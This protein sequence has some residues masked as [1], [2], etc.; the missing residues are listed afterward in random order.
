[1]TTRLGW[2]LVSWPI[3]VL[4][5][6]ASP[7]PLPQGFMFDWTPQG[8]APLAPITAQCD[9]VHIKW[10]RGNAEGPSPIAPYYLQVYTSTFDVPLVVEVGSVLEFDWTVPFVPGTQYQI[11][12]FDSKGVSG[13]CQAI[14]TVYQAPNTTLQSPPTCPNLTYP[15][16]EQQIGVVGLVENGPFS[17]FAT[18]DQCTDLSIMPTNGTPPYTLSIAPALHPH[19]NISSMDQSPINWTVSLSSGMSFFVSLV[20]STGMLW[21]SGPLF[22]GGGGNTNCLSLNAATVDEMNLSTTGV[23]LPVAV[24]I[25][26]TILGLAVGLFSAWIYRSKLRRSH[27]VTP[28][29]FKSMEDEKTEDSL[30]QSLY[31]D[32]EYNVLSQSGG[33][34]AFRLPVTPDSAMSSDSVT[35][36]TSADSTTPLVPLRRHSAGASPHLLLESIIR[37]IESDEAVGGDAVHE[38]EAAI[39]ERPPSITPNLSSDPSHPNPTPLSTCLDGPSRLRSGRPLPVPSSPPSRPLPQTP[40]APF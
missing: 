20:D 31:Q 14:Y 38:P 30:S 26:G 5:K 6:A 32:L 16:P 1:M 29:G 12:M 9:T 22:S 36:Y 18:I 13:G 33:V 7:T 34:E 21:S 17:R 8:G 24:G 28:T 10:G 23:V 19:Y 37:V 3:Y 15:Q 35:S 40:L 25:G 39:V 4:S 27:T 2:L 11:C